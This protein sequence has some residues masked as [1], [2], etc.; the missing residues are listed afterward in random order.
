MEPCTIITFFF[1]C[2]FLTLL[3]FRFWRL[4]EREVVVPKGADIRA[5]LNYLHFSILIK[6]AQLPEKSRFSTTKK[7]KVLFLKNFR[8]NV[9]KVDFPKERK[10]SFK[11]GKTYFYRCTQ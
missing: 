3:S 4:Y 11:F 10:K 1:A 9:K 6:W 8:K 5:R 7:N 2:V